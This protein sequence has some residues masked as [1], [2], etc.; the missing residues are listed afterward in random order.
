[1]AHRILQRLSSLVDDVF[2]ED[3]VDEGDLLVGGDSAKWIKLAVSDDGTV[4]Y[5]TKS[6][7]DL[8]PTNA[9]NSLTDIVDISLETI[10]AGTTN[11]VFNSVLDINSQEIYAASNIYTDAGGTLA[12]DITSSYLYD[13]SGNVSID[14]NNH[15]LNDSSGNLAVEYGNR[16]LYDASG[17]VAIDWGS[18]CIYDQ[19]SSFSLDFNLR[20]A[21]DSSSG[22]QFDW[23]TPGTV[24]FQTN[25]ITTS[26][27]ISG[28]SIGGAS[29]D[30]GVIR[31]ISPSALAIDLD[32]RVLYD[33]DGVATMLNWST[34]GTV[35]FYDNDLTTT[36]TNTAGYGIIN[37][38]ADL[39]GLQVN[40]FDDEAAQFFKVMHTGVSTAEMRTSNNMKFSSL[41]GYLWFL[42]DDNIYFNVG[43]TGGAYKVLF[44]DSASTVVTDM[45]SAGDWDFKTGDLTTT[46][47]LSSGGRIVGTDTYTAN[48]PLDADNYVVVGDTDSVGAF[49]ISLPAGVT[50][51]TYKIVC[52]GA[53]ALTVAPNGAELLFGA[54][55]N[56][57]LNDN[58]TIQITYTSKGWY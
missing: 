58:E 12:I 33:S 17:N 23:D 9:N 13:S 2:I 51:T 34:D 15:Y 5:W 38:Q 35:D 16:Y 53:A 21:Y 10:T 28:G 4:G 42:S 18:G 22:T 7:T 47:V 41:N 36:G 55:S 19:A 30:G 26:G 46:G 40:G 43:G 1:M 8:S 49:T 14:W 37:Q 56:F 20:Q 57:V 52:S 32:N 29:I 6:G 25:D 39:D 44:R 48:Q 27:I 31:S 24:H 54:N 11:I 3:A 50:G 45:T